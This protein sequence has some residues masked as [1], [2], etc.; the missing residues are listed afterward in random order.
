LWGGG[1]PVPALGFWG[2]LALGCLLGVCGVLVLR[3]KRRLAAATVVL[4]LL[5]PLTAIAAVPFVFTNGQIA[6]AT[7][8]NADFAALTPIQGQSAAS[9]FASGSQSLFPSSPS[10]TAPRNLTCIVT[11]EANGFAGSP[12]QVISF[13]SAIKVGSTQTPG[14]AQN[15]FFNFGNTNGMDNNYAQTYTQVFTVASGSS[16]SF[17]ALVFSTMSFQVNV[18][19]V[20]NCI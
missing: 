7:Q 4:G 1:T 17:G 8:V 6:D 3:N 15:L 20:Y 11:V 13:N 10:F 5:V 2:A 16:V 19:A 14:S 12:N 18:L 9:G